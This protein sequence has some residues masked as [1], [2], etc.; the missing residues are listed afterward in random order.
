MTNR[1]SNPDDGFDEILNAPMI[2]SPEAIYRATLLRI[3]S[4]AGGLVETYASQEFK[5]LK[6][7]LIRVVGKIR[8]EMIM[9]E[10]L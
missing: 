3:R 4:V 6:S 9:N 2:Q 7:D 1:H 8:A 5:R 10:N